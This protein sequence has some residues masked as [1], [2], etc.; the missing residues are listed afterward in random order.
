[1]RHILAEVV[2]SN[3][4]PLQIHHAP[5]PN[6]LYFPPYK[7]SFLLDAFD[8]CLKCCHPSPSHRM[9]DGFRVSPA[10]FNNFFNNWYWK[11]FQ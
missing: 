1:M 5:K 4:Q 2:L 9:H 10:V 8:A 11:M 6:G 3:L 7:P